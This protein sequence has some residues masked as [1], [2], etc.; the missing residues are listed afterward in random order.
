[1]RQ[2]QTTPLKTDKK[3]HENQ[4]TGKKHEKWP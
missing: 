1:M 2:K 3:S 4:K